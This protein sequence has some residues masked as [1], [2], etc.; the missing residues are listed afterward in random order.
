VQALV[1]DIQTEEPWVVLVVEKHK[2][3]FPL[4]SRACFSVI[5]FSPGSRSNNK[6]RAWDTLGQP[7]E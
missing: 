3:I 7:L 5:P 2:V 1:L 4:D 6:V